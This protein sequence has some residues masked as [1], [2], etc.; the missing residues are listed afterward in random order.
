MWRSAALRV[1]VFLLVG[2]AGVYR[3]ANNFWLYRGFAPPK[4]ASWV[5]ATGTTERLYV[6]GPALG[7][8]RQPV[9]VYLPPGYF[10][11]PA[12]RYPVLYLLHG[13]PGRPGAFLST[14]RMGVV[15]D[16]LVG[17][18][19]AQPLI[20]VM[21]FGST[22]SFT[23]EEWA[24]GV[25]P[26]QRLG[27]LCRRRPGEGDRRA[28]TGPC[29]RRAGRG[30][31]GL[32]E[33]GYGALNIGLH[34]PGE[35]RVLESWSGYARAADIGAIFGHRRALLADEHA[36]GHARAGGGGTQAGARLRLVLQRHRRQVPV[37]ERGVRPGSDA[38]RR[39][40]PLLPRAR[41]AQL[42]ALARQRGRRLPRG[43]PQAPGMRRA[44]AAPPVLVS[45][46]L[47]S[48]RRPAGSTSFGPACPGRASAR[49]CPS[50]SCP[51]IRRR[52]SRATCW[53]GPR[54]GSRSARFFAGPAS[55]G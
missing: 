30:L 23:D 3:Y 31:A 39:A 36:A 21:P 34:H 44:V 52:R 20:L 35:F 27:V 14:V 37:P 49:R 5:R 11:H 42:G 24:N 8:R 41:R 25:R 29:A 19:K 18:R 32:S 50:M 6:A 46:V 38:G 16:E 12:R 40:A 55:N 22:G 54:P 45:I 7:G 28:A 33:G 26:G 4:D 9:D 47:G 1:A 43:Q 13:V 15:E 17:R 10:A 48:A 51:A 2:L 53:S